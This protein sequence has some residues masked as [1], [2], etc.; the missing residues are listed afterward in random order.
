[1]T[2]IYL[3]VLVLLNLFVTFF[4]FQ[5]A[6]KLLNYRP[7]RWRLLGGTLLG[8]VYSLLILFELNTA[9]LVTIKLVMGASLVFAVFFQKRGGWKALVRSGLYFSLVNFLF[10]GFM[11]A[12]WL[13]AAPAGM[14]YR[15]GVAYFNISALTLALS[16]IAAYLVLTL[17]TFLL[18]RRSRKAELVET[19]VTLRGRQVVLTGFVDT[20][21]KLCD[22]FTGL[23]VAVCEY[24][25]VQELFPE[26]VRGF[27]RDPAGFS[28]E[29]LEDSSLKTLLRVIPVNAVS[30]ASSLPAF[31]PDELI[32]DGVPRQ[33][34]VAVTTQPLSDGS[35]HALLS[36]ALTER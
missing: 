34:V 23:P 2:T 25:A 28:F 24:E 7:N 13:F 22:I 19:T 30:G 1:M 11:Q 17:F 20:G 10:A 5:A 35:F 27:F 6:A 12:L 26:R 16:T 4:L 15:N 9:E 14:S 8:G 3:D 36:P 29:S 33:A 18:N 21:N 31:K 32:T